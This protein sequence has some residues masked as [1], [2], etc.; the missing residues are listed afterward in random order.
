[1][2]NAWIGIF[3]LAALSFPGGVPAASR[4]YREI[5][6]KPVS[7]EP[8][9]L[10]RD[11]PGDWIFL[12]DLEWKEASAGWSRNGDR[13]PRRDRDA[14]GNALRLGGRRFP[15]GIGTHAPSRI[16]YN[17][18]GNFTRFRA[19]AGGAE[20]GGT[21]QFEVRGDGRSLYR[22]PVLQGLN[23]FQ[24]VDVSVEGVHLLELDVS[25]GGNGFICDMANWAL[26]RVRKSGPEKV[27][28]RPEVAQVESTPQR[29]TVPLSV[30]PDVPEI[31][32]WDWRFRET[33]PAIDAWERICPD[34]VPE[35]G[36]TEWIP[37]LPVPVSETGGAASIWPN[38]IPE[39]LIPWPEEMA[40][41]RL[42]APS[43]SSV[44]IERIPAEGPAKLEDISAGQAILGYKHVGGGDHDMWYHGYSRAFDRLCHFRPE[45]APFS[46]RI[47]APLDLRPGRGH[48]PLELR[49]VASGETEI[50]LRVDIYRPGEEPRSAEGSFRLPPNRVERIAVP[51]T[52]D[53]EGGGLIVVTLRVEGKPYRLPFFTHVEKIEPILTGIE[54]TLGD[55]PD[56]EG[57]RELQRLRAEHR[58]LLGAIGCGNAPP[59]AWRTAFEAACALR[60]RILME[61]IDF[62]ELLFAKRKPFISEQ[63]YM[64]A[65][66]LYNLPGGGIYRLKPVRPDGI[67]RPVVDHLGEG[68]YRDVCLSWDARRILF[69]FGQGSDDWKPDAQSYHIYEVGVDGGGLRQLTFGPKNDCEPFYLPN[70]KIGFTSDR[71]EHFVL[72]GGPRHASTLFSMEP[73]G[74]GIVQL[75]FNVVNDFNPSI[76]PDGRIIY[77]RWEY[78]E[79]SVTSLHSLFTMR[80]DGSQVAPFYG[81]QSIRPNVLMFPRAVPNS[82]KVLALLTGHHGQTHGPVGLIDVRRDTNGMDMVEVLTPGMPVIGEKIED[83]R[84]GWASRPWPLSEETFLLSYT[85]TIVPWRERSWAIYV[86]DR[87]G[88]MAL[89]FRDPAISTT[90]PIPLLPAP[91]PHVIRGARAGDD[92]CDF[93]LTAAFYLY[94]AHHGQPEIERGSARYL[95][96]IEDVPRKGVHQGGVIPV[97]ATSMYTVKRFIGTVPVEADGSAFFRVP[98]NRPLYF[99][100]LDA[101]GL[102]I[103][104]MRSSLCVRPGEVQSCAGCHESR[105]ST[106]PSGARLTLAIRR[107]PSIPVPPPW[108][109]RTISFLRDVQPL[110]ERSCLPC[111]E[112]GR[113]EK[114]VILSDELTDQFAVSYEELLPYTK[115]AY[116]TRWDVPFD[117]YRVP[118]RSFGSGA[119]PL[120][121]LLKKEH[122]GVKLESRDRETL[123]MWIDSNSV[124][125][126]WYRE[127]WPN[128]H[129][130][131]GRFRKPLDAI[132]AR[133]CE[134]CHG[135][136]EGRQKIRYPA[137]HPAEPAKSRALLAPLAKTAGGWGACGE[138]VFRHRDDPDFQAFSRGFQELGEALRNRP[139][140]DLLDL[141]EPD[142]AKLHAKR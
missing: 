91:R 17:L 74:S 134:S 20:K 59:E 81:N 113:E 38:P 128:R 34:L 10:D 35:A 71:P 54:K 9:A 73:D 75:S 80:P 43:P 76:L 18:G 21:V 39:P 68:I 55:R 26:A 46:L 8:V 141:R 22:S 139:R 98:A 1:M 6:L 133:R 29:M 105:H 97:S 31:V 16:L 27:K 11:L 28:S 50:N 130:F 57:A 112:R 70:G 86:S 66:H 37:V 121:A 83:S 96:I 78:N 140:R 118:P 85:P 14:Q 109:M 4:D 67:A 87:H 12:S 69:S 48:I 42:H 93:E 120:M 138:N 117:V 122:H 119:S 33:L 116:A 45:A 137:I 90:E 123:A 94:D 63:P 3:I 77:T 56:S 107:E 51:V 106:P 5:P 99:S 92:A 72:C 110:L 49:S 88:N 103:Q 95:R 135:G 25:D 60:R 62:D 111:H 47:P 13:L 44:R 79:R 24:P 125:F 101:E 126:G 32:R 124:Y 114:K 115:N 108:G 53:W 100:L 23:G 64:D 131:T 61:R 41:L 136:D 30:P 7:E 58:E 15:K 142:P 2:A 36:E 104:R 89:V 40:E 65:H 82:P 127:S 19:F 102:E 84:V 132:F 129:I 52:L